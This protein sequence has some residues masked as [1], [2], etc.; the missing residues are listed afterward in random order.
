M[1]GHT[2]YFLED[3]IPDVGL[4]A[5]HSAPPPPRGL[6]GLC[7]CA[8]PSWEEGTALCVEGIQTLGGVQLQEGCPQRRSTRLCPIYLPHHQ[9]HNTPGLQAKRFSPCVH[10]GG[11]GKNHL[12]PVAHRPA[13]SIQ[14]S[15]SSPSHAVG[16]AQCPTVLSSLGLHIHCVR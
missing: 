10:P 7:V 9:I 6:V 1:G 2:R 15:L 12:H 13:F 16:R 11:S 5:Q 4:C 14:Q 8:S 3:Q